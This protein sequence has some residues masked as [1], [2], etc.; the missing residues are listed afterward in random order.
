[1]GAVIRMPNRVDAGKNQNVRGRSARS[2]EQRFRHPGPDVVSEVSC[3]GGRRR[4]R[5]DSERTARRVG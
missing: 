4:A 2:T 3:H 5:R 1:M